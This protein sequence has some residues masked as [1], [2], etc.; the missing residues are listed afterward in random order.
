MKGH[1]TI[2]NRAFYKES[3]GYSHVL[4][5]SLSCFPRICFT[6][7]SAIL[8]FF[9]FSAKGRNSYCGE[10]IAVLKSFS[11]KRGIT[12]FGGKVYKN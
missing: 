5:S 6:L 7:R 2:F 10:C 1:T 4:A 12:I 9:Y 11:S 8:I 3:F